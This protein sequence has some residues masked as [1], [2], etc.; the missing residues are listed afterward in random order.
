VFNAANEVAVAAFL[1][2]ALGFCDVA[3]VIEATLAQHSPVAID[4]LE[5]VLA[6]DRWARVVAGEASRSRC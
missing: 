4:S 5:T 6:A 1:E 3:A 2:G